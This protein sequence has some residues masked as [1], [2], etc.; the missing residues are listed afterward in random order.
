MF[1]DLSGGV[2]DF[3]ET[4]LPCPSFC[5]CLCIPAYD[6]GPRAA[7]GSQEGKGW[8]FAH[9]ERGLSEAGSDYDNTLCVKA[10]SLPG[11]DRRA[12]R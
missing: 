1:A 12:R 5:Y 9:S 2:K 4:A 11:I 8:L 6:N 3:P 10:L 7:K